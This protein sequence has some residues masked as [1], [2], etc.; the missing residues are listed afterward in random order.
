MPYLAYHVDLYLHTVCCVQCTTA[1]RC[2]QSVLHGKWSMVTSWPLCKFVNIC[3]VSYR[4]FLV[5]D[6]GDTKI[7]ILLCGNSELT[8]LFFQSCQISRG[9]RGKSVLLMSEHKHHCHRR[10]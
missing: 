8:S 6:E 3:F 5:Q 7:V 1:H 4:Q 2:S 9:Q 10:V